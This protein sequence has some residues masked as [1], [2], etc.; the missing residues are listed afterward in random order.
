[1]SI[2]EVTDTF[3]DTTDVVD[4]TITEVIDTIT[5]TTDVVDTEATHDDHELEATHS[6]SKYT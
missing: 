3:A 6:Q 2:I 4:T 5:D 1:M